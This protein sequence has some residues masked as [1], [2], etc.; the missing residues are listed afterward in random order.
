MAK[1]ASYYQT[2]RLC[3]CFWLWLKWD[4]YPSIPMHFKLS[5]WTCSLLYPLLM[6]SGQTISSS[7]Q[8]EVKVTCNVEYLCK[9]PTQTMG[10]L[11]CSAVLTFSPERKQISVAKWTNLFC[12]MLRKKK[13][14]GLFML[15]ESEF[16]ALSSSICPLRIYIFKYNI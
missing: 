5:F 10:G 8:K 6:Q 7:V 9:S 1:W 14:T 3:L 16:E 2:C 4:I 13:K 15:T 12:L 11:P